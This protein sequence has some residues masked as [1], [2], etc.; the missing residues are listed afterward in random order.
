MDQFSPFISDEKFNISSSSPDVELYEKIP[1]QGK[2]FFKCFA[3]SCDK[4]F[5]F[6]SEV[7]SHVI[8]HTKAKP[9]V[10]SHS[11][12]KRAFKRSDALK[13]HM[14]S[15]QEEM[16]LECPVLGY[17]ARFQKKSTFQF[18]LFKHQKLNHFLCSSEGCHQT[19]TSSYELKKT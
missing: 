17:K 1:I 10:C 4:V 19:F 7:E 2:T 11:S 12:C 18:H 3:S 15:H 14:D 6:K 9:F 5:Q 8:I 16:P 13:N